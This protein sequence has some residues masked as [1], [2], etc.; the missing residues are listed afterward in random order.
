MN[1]S[2]SIHQETTARRARLS[3]LATDSA[4]NSGGGVRVSE[5]A[6]RIGHN[7]SDS[8]PIGRVSA[9]L[10]VDGDA[11][12]EGASQTTVADAALVVA[13]R[14]GE[15]QTRRTGAATLS[16]MNVCCGEGGGNVGA[17]DVDQSNV[18]CE[19]ESQSSVMVKGACLRAGSPAYVADG[20]L[21]NVNAVVKVA[22]GT[23]E[24]AG[25]G[26]VQIDN[27]V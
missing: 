11:G 21:G 16:F 24:T 9:R 15:G 20:V 7:L 1:R 25:E 12:L 10:A 8:E 27:L 22:H 4:G 5:E 19:R 14:V 3:K 26:V 13:L 6:S 2:Q 18:L 17:G 23:W